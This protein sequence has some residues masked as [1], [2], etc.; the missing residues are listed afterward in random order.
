MHAKHSLLIKNDYIRGLSADHG[1]YQQFL[2]YEQ[3]GPEETV[4]PLISR[5]N[6]NIGF[7]K[8]FTVRRINYLVAEIVPED[9]ERIVNWQLVGGLTERKLF[10][11]SW[12]IFPVV[13]GV[14]DMVVGNGEM[15]Q[16]ETWTR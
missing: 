9:R 14:I 8:G 1:V 13:V 15:R 4:L 11:D 12:K 5:V 2:A 6:R 10:P 7:E 16:S 3:H